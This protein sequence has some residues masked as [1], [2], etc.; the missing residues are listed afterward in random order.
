[1]LNSESDECF[2]DFV[3]LG[4]EKLGLSLRDLSSKSDVA[5]TYISQIE[6]GERLPSPDI[7]IRLLKS[8]RYSRDAIASALTMCAGE[9]GDAWLDKARS[10]LALALMFALGCAPPDSMEA[11]GGDGL[12][13]DDVVRVC[14]QGALVVFCLALPDESRGRCLRSRAPTIGCHIIDPEDA[15]RCDA[16]MAR[17]C[18]LG[19]VVC[20]APMRLAETH[21]GEGCLCLLD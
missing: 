7:A 17:I 10:L 15:H 12:V 2:G 11:D 5:F 9:V 20:H 16:A 3:F 6:R 19:D 4:R 1:M 13:D 8:L 14:D 18:L 21:V